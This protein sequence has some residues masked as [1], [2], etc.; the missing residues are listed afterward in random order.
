[1][2]F[3]SDINL[4]N[5]TVTVSAANITYADQLSYGVTAVRYG[6][7]RV[8][9]VRA[10]LDINPL[11]TSDGSVRLFVNEYASQYQ[12]EDTP[13][14]TTFGPKVAMTFSLATR[15]QV[16][17]VSST[18]TIYTVGTVDTFAASITLRL[19]HDCFCEFY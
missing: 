4:T 7:V 5:P 14:G 2:R 19:T 18:S 1:V 10:W 3:A 15:N 6:S 16:N 17:V 8:M 12:V 11:S 9:K 13:V